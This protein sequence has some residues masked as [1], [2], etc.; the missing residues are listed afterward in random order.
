MKETLLLLAVLPTGVRVLG[1]AYLPSG[2][3][4]GAKSGQTIHGQGDKISK[5]MQF[6][7]PCSWSGVGERNFFLKNDVA[8]SI[9]TANFY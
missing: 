7:K 6:T 4:T 5:A 2:L 8:P 3:P 9:I 1:L